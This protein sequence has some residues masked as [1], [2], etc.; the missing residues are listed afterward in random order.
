MCSRVFLK[1]L[2]SYAK[3]SRVFY[4]VLGSCQYLPEESIVF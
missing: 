1:F 3:G 4:N 2:F